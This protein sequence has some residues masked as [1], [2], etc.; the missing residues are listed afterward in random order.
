MKMYEDIHSLRVCEDR[1]TISP[2]G[3]TGQEKSL[4]MERRHAQSPRRMPLIVVC[5]RP[6]V[7]KSTFSLK[8]AEYLAEK[9]LKNVHVVTADQ[10]RDATSNKKTM[11]SSA[12]NEKMSRGQLKSTVDRLLTKESTVICDGANYIK[13]FRYELYCAARAVGT[14]LVCVWVGSTVPLSAALAVNIE[15]ENRDDAY[16]PRMLRDL[17]LRFEPPDARNKWECPLVIAD[18][19]GKDGESNWW[20]VYAEKGL[21]LQTELKEAAEKAAHAVTGWTARDAAQ[22]VAFGQGPFLTSKFDLGTV[23]ATMERSSEARKALQQGSTNKT[24][25]Y[26]P[27]FQLDPDVANQRDLDY[28]LGDNL[29]EGWEF[30]LDKESEM[31]FEMEKLEINSHDE[32]VGTSQ[33]GVSPPSISATASEPAEKILNTPKKKAAESAF[34][35]AGKGKKVNDAEPA[36]QN[37]EAEAVATTIPSKPIAAH[38]SSNNEEGNVSSELGINNPFEE[39]LQAMK[40]TVRKGVLGQN[41]AN[42]QAPVYSSNFMHQLDLATGDIVTSLLAKASISKDNV[43]LPGI[44]WISQLTGEVLADVPEDT[45]NFSKLNIPRPVSVNELRKLRHTFERMITESHSNSETMKEF[46]LSLTGAKPDILEK[47][48]R[49]RFIEY[50]DNILPVKV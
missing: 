19:G 12:A 30:D 9:N 45:T 26:P 18:F 43:C 32:P 44:F 7:G 3:G 49:K 8:L 34:K 6:C 11:F 17:W 2:G 47:L 27:G 28:Y 33:G 22:Y 20:D 16:D 41:A 39:V 50:V 5:G 42:V 31:V 13:G 14:Y 40:D 23:K 35:R 48:I 21:S 38:V 46:R 24:R 15:R 29:D 37:V 1:A 10:T 36:A 25:R 4:S